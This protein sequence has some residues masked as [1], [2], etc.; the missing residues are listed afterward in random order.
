MHLKCNKIITLVEDIEDYGK[1]G[2]ICQKK[3]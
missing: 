1:I 2:Q 3:I